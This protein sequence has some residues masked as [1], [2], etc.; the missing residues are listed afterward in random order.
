MGPGCC[1]YPWR[2][3]RPVQLS[4]INFRACI[5]YSIVE[6]TLKVTLPTLYVCVYR[7]S[8]RHVIKYNISVKN[9]R[10]SLLQKQ[11]INNQTKNFSKH[12]H[13]FMNKCYNKSDR[14]K[15]R[16]KNTLLNNG[17]VWLNNIKQVQQSSAIFWLA[18]VQKIYTSS[19]LLKKQKQT[20]KLLH[21]L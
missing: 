6:Y 10:V 19:K 12:L 4:K 3:Y 15:H 2:L 17:F 5:Q 1:S 9:K 7:Y 13:L 11:R 8:N 18:N 14:L 20:S 21:L 16:H